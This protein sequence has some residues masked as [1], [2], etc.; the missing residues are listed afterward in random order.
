PVALVFFII[1]L[2][3]IFVTIPFIIYHKNKHRFSSTVRYRRN[4]DDA[5]SAK[6]IT[7]DE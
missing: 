4:F 7:D 3:C 6:M 2:I 5:D 1:L